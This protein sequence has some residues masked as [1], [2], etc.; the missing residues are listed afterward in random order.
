MFMVSTE[1][2]FLEDKI[3]LPDFSPQTA[4]LGFLADLED[5]YFMILNHLLLISA[6]LHIKEVR[7]FKI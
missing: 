6:Y 3:S 1:K 2:Y 5:T 4:M 7:N